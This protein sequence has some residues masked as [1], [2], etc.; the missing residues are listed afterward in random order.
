M[1][2]PYKEEKM[3]QTQRERPHE[4]GVRDLSCVHKPRDTVNCQQPLLA[5]REAWKG[6][7][8]RD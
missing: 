3:K 6:F 7:F 1:I 5:R 2:S 8:L 4:D